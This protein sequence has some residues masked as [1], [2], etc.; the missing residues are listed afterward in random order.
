MFSLSVYF[1]PIKLLFHI[2][3]NFISFSELLASPRNQKVSFKNVYLTVL[4][5]QL[6]FVTVSSGYI[7]NDNIIFNPHFFFHYVRDR[8][9]TIEW[10]RGRYQNILGQ[11]LTVKV[12][13][14][15]LLF[16]FQ[17][18]FLLRQIKCLPVAHIAKYHNCCSSRE[19]K[20][21]SLIGNL[22]LSM[23]QLRL[24]L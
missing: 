10:Q 7:L 9:F 1:L 4:G 6:T 3:F 22:C 11:I 18:T 21:T 16:S 20:V 24:Y 12:C 19:Q 14:Y 23:G 8:C 5:I 2:T 15:F 13:T 17:F